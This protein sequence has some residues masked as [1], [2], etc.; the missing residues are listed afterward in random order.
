MVGTKKFLP[1][2]VQS[3]VSGRLKLYRSGFSFVATNDELSFEERYYP[4]SFVRKCSLQ[5]RPNILTD[6]VSYIFL[7]TSQISADALGRSLRP[8]PYYFCLSGTAEDNL[9]T[10]RAEYLNCIAESIRQVNL[11]MFPRESHISTSS[12]SSAHT[13]DLVM[14]GYLLMQ[15]DASTVQAVYAV[16][17]P[18]DG[19]EFR[20]VLYDDHTC[21]LPFFKEIHV[22][23]KTPCYENMGHNCCCFAVDNV[24]FSAR[25]T[26]ERRIWLRALCNL[27]V[28]IQSKA[29]R[30]NAIELAQWRM[31]IEEHLIDIE[32]T[33]SAEIS[34]SLF[35]RC[36]PPHVTPVLG[37][38]PCDDGSDNFSDFY[39]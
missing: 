36:G 27:K 15:L 5:M 39:L 30:P 38:E 23:P 20:F 2:K 17:Y 18:H 21:I 8:R 29:E 19:N 1:E 25:S 26:L 16:I 9:M 33:S 32:E 37:D 4:H 28:K 7:I 35:P 12:G 6:P 10:K 13:A 34:E 22:S 31:A 14:A 11:S 3:V 24:R